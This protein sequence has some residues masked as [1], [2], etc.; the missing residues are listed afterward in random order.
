MI[1]ILTYS[2]TG[3]RNSV[4]VDTKISVFCHKQFYYPGTSKTSYIATCLKNGD[5]SPPLIDCQPFRMVKY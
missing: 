2:I 5:F 3:G 1:P 4:L